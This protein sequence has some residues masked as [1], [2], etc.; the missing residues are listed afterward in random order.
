MKSYKYIFMIVLFVLPFICISSVQA[1][2]KAKV[3]IPG[4]ASCDL[5]KG[6][7]GYCFYQDKNLNKVDG[8]VRWLDAGD[9]VTVLTNYETVPTKNKNLCSDYYVYTSFYYP[10]DG[11]LYYGYY[12]NEYLKTSVLTSE[13]EKEFTDAGF[14]RSYFEK[15][16]VL[17]LAHPNWTFKAVKT[18]LDWKSAVEKES[19]VGMSLIDGGEEGYYSTLGG[20][21]DYYSDTFKVKEGSSWYAASSGVVAY[22]MDPRNFLNTEFIFQFETLESNPSIQTIDGVKAVLKDNFMLKNAEAFITAAENSGVSSVYLAALASQ[23]VGNGTVAT[24]GEGFTYSSGNK[25]YP[26]LRGKWINGGFYNV[27][28]IG[29]GTDTVPAQNSVIYARGGE[30]SNETSYDRPWKSLDEAIIGGAKFIGA[31]YLSTGQYTMYSKKFNVHPDSEKGYTV[32]SHQYQTNI[33]GAT[34]EGSKVRA[35]YLELGIL[36]QPFTFAIPVY[37]NM[38]SETTMPNKG[39]PNNY[40]ETL[41]YK[42][43]NEE[44]SVPEFNGGITD[45]TVYVEYSTSKV[46]IIATSVKNKGSISNTGEKNLNVGDNKFSIVVT[47]QNGDKRTYNLNI[48]RSANESGEPTVD[49]IVEKLGVKSDGKYFSGIDLTLEMNTLVNKVKSISATAD[50]NITNSKNKKDSKTFATGD[51]VSITSAG[52]TKA[53]EVVIYGDTNG[54]AKITS[55]DLLR[56]QKNILGSIKLTGAESIAANPTKS[57]KISVRDLLKV[58]RHIL[59]ISYIEQ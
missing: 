23:E 44:I 12:C 53:Y 27:Y 3:S 9:E 42:V 51:V 36:D 41:K 58:Q 39:N 32:Y 15:L 30:N 17:K 19:A 46:T 5:Y 48:V 7:T 14:D 43:G 20:S 57:G 33:R 8:A 4:S 6:S 24:K 25:K 45:Y 50:V 2:Y 55:L 1:D 18:G 35:A 59:E 31:N 52:E 37:E 40:L 13:L 16:A 34:S 54:D 21:Y 49:E 29:A 56:I 28:N 11:K 38:P 22:Y 10:K 47:A 26:S